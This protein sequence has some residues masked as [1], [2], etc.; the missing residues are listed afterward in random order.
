MRVAFSLLGLIEIWL[1]LVVVLLDGW[2]NY[3]RLMSNGFDTEGHHAK[4]GCLQNLFIM[5]VSI[6]ALKLLMCLT[7]RRAN[8]KSDGV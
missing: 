5:M 2:P 4:S 1:V 8:E 3:T 7:L 6:R